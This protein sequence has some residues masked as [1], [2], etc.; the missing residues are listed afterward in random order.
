MSCIPV[1]RRDRVDDNILPSKLTTLTRDAVG[2]CATLSAILKSFAAN[3]I[4]YHGKWIL[5][6]IDNDIVVEGSI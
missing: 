4:D 6:E 1:Y 5:S 3:L 2:D